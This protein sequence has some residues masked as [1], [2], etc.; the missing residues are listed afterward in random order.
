MGEYMKKAGLTRFE[1]DEVQ[2]EFKNRGRFDPSGW[3]PTVKRQHVFV[4]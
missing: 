4:K 2:K 3:T 1:S